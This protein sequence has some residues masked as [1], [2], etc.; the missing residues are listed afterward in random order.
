MGG[1]EVLALDGESNGEDV[2]MEA[3]PGGTLV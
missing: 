1:G 3:N 2:K